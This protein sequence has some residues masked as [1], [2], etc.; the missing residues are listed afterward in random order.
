MLLFVAVASTASGHTLKG[1]F[2]LNGTL[3][4]VPIT[5]PSACNLKETRLGEH[6]ECAG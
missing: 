5:H 2:H 4:F 1:S 6:I 3:S